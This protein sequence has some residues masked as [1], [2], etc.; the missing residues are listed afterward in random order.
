MSAHIK[1]SLLEGILSYKEAVEFGKPRKAVDLLFM[2]VARLHRDYLKGTLVDSLMLLVPDAMFDGYL[3]SRPEAHYSKI[4]GCSDDVAS[5]ERWV[6]ATMQYINAMHE[7]LS[8]EDR[9]AI[10]A[11]LHIRLEYLYRKRC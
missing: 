8:S 3:A 4:D 6:S 5:D 2:E 10:K 11:Q 1:E 7:G 9:H